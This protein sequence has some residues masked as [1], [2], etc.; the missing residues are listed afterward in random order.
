MTVTLFKQ[1]PRAQI[2]PKFKN[3]FARQIAKDQTIILSPE[4]W[5]ISFVPKN[6]NLPHF[7]PLLGKILVLRVLPA[8]RK[9]I[10]CFPLNPPAPA[11]RGGYN[12][13]WRPAFGPSCTKIVY[14]GCWHFDNGATSSIDVV[15]IEHCGLPHVL[16]LAVHLKI[17]DGQVNGIILSKFYS[18]FG[19]GPLLHAYSDFT[20]HSSRCTLRNLC[21]SKSP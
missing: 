19:L 9:K 18:G 13:H 5:P 16:P 2:G 21:C 4:L 12:P 3:F 7:L 17:L 14:P 6:V 15:L 1:L 10:G 11:A 20:L 8:Y